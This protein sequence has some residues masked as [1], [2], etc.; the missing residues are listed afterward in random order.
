ME[1]YPDSIRFFGP[2]SYQSGLIIIELIV[3]SRHLSVY[4]RSTLGRVD[5]S[6]FSTN[7]VVV[8]E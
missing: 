5:A 3:F 6:F 8:P 1:N 7:H 4:H 2:N